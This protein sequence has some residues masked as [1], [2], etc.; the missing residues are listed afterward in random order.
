M[1]PEQLLRGEARTGG[2]K[3]RYNLLNNSV[4]SSNRL[5]C[6]EDDVIG[7]HLKPSGQHKVRRIASIEMQR[8]H[9]FSPGTVGGTAQNVD[10]GGVAGLIVEAAFG[11]KR[12][13]KAGLTPEGKGEAARFGDLAR[14]ID[15][16]PIHAIELD[17]ITEV[18]ARLVQGGTAQIHL[19]RQLGQCV[20][21]CALLVLGQLNLLREIGLRAAQR[22]SVSTKTLSSAVRRSFCSCGLFK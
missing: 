22:Y 3:R 17:A 13:R 11:I 8:R 9:R 21:A 4:P 5:F 19:G 7:S 15:I 18:G 12:I 6:D 2:Q 10:L 16:I 1:P 20:F 14:K